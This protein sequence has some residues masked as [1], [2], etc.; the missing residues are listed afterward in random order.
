MITEW[1]QMVADLLSGIAG[2]L[3]AADAA[4]RRQG[5]ADPDPAGEELTASI[6]KSRMRRDWMAWEKKDEVRVAVP[7][8]D[9]LREGRL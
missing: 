2:H 9:L 1:D 6:E 3:A 8:A 5:K 7:V 4:D